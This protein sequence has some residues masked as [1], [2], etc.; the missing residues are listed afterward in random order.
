[1]TAAK[2]VE[3]DFETRSPVDLRT[4]GVYVYAAHPDT[5]VLMAAYKID[6]GPTRRWLRGD[7]CPLDLR[8]AIEGGAV[9]EAHN[10]TF[11]RLMIN[12]IL[13]PRHGWPHLPLAQCRC[14]AATAAAL[15]LPRKLGDLG[16]A[17]GLTVRKDKRGAA[18]IRKFSIPRR[19]A[20]AG[21]RG[22]NAAV[23][24]LPDAGTRNARGVPLHWNEPEDHPA[25]FR[26]FRDYNAADVDSEAEAAGR[27]VPLSDDELDLWR[28]SERINDRGL[29]IDVT[30][31]RAALRLAGK[32]R[33]LL[34]RDMRLATGG[35]VTTCT[36]VGRLTEW[37][38]RQGVA[39]P[40]AAK[41]DLEDVL[42]RD[43]IPAT[44]RRAVE[45]RQEAAK[46]S[47]SK[48]KAF[49]NRASHDGRIRGAFLY[50]AA[51]TGRWS[52]TGAQVH[53]LPRPRKVFEDAHLD[54]RVLFQAIRTENPEWLTFLYGDELGKPL[55][56]L[57]D[58]IRGFI[59]AEPGCDILDADYAGIEGAVAAWF[60]GEDW[61]VK[62]MFDLMADPDLPDLYRRAAAGIF[63][64]TTAELTRKDP[65]RQ[66]G[67]VSELS[68]QY[69][70]GPGAFR[71]MARNY[72]MK[73]DPLYAPVWAA[74][75]QHRREAALRRYE[76]V[77]R[78][79]LPIAGQLTRREFLAAELV[80]AGWRDTHPAITAAW[81]LLQDGVTEAV[82]NPG[83][84]VTVLK[85]RYLV[86]N[87]FLWCQLPSGRCLA[88]GAPHLRQ[89]VW[90]RKTGAGVSETMGCT[91][92]GRLE[93]AGGCVIER[94]A[95]PAVTV[96]GVESQSQKLVRY[97]LYGGLLLENVVQ[98]IARDLLAHGIRQAEKA[99]YPV[100]GHVHDEILCEVP[101]GFGD[102]KTFERLICERP[103]WAAGLPLSSGGW[104]GKR[105]R[106]D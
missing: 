84:V 6:G 57:S 2:R 44:V 74:A 17:L 67:K 41:A 83:T 90:V 101:R 38:K 104:R 66:V 87:G 61:K 86:R 37:V 34:D 18:L 76:T 65:R 48:L 79:N 50:H 92:A 80:K 88:Y 8:A 96:L 98:A 14:T 71:S 105:F 85:A 9:V 68:L 26:D 46:T 27:M 39:L 78:Q 69:Q 5:E 60:C 20:T 19:P 99:G 13:A 35:Y 70:G 23:D 103:A 95:R 16:T 94:A 56:L 12:M 49:L 29:R 77:L 24:A 106:K 73:L 81:A 21:Q 100:I 43:D 63:N 40:S 82:A 62:A 11:E 28:I 33:A 54:T 10:N 7:P 30:S 58:A 59:W 3:L 42:A 51:G 1:M 15:S 31:C 22:C 93:A 53:N 47:V 72:S 97:A 45:I 64:T 52:S 32:A 25:D 91:E 102:V 75:P 4:R 55:H 36:Q 89:Q